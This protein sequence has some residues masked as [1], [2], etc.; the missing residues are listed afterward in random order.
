MQAH[1]HL[2]IQVSELLPLSFVEF[3]DRVILELCLLVLCLRSKSILVLLHLY[4]V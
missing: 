4:S 3:A 2:G 1:R